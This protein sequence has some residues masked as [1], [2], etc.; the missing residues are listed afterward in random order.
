MKLCL[1]PIAL[2]VSILSAVPA[3]ADD[4]ADLK[5]Q[6][7][8]LSERV[9]NLEKELTRTT[10]TDT[11]AT[12]PTPVTISYP[13]S[14]Q[15]ISGDTT[16]SLYG[17]LDATFATQNHA[18]AF[19]NRGS[20]PVVSWM[21]GNRFGIN[22]SHTLDK[23]SGLK[24]IGRLE[25]E[26][27][28][29]T[30]N[31]D[32]PNVLF[33][34][35]AW[36]GLQ[37]EGLGKFTIGRQ[38]TLPR[39]FAQT[40]G[41]A[42]GSREVGLDEGG[43][44]NNNQMQYMINYAGGANGT[45]YNSAMVWKKQ[46]GQWVTGLAHQ[47]N[48]GGGYVPGAF[49]TGTTTAAAVA[50]NGGVWNVSGTFSRADIAGFIHQVVGIGGNVQ[51]SP[52][53]LVRAGYFHNSADQAVVGRRKDDVFTTSVT[54]TPSSLPRNQF[55]L[56]YYNIKANNAGYAA[57]G[58]TLGVNSDTSAVTTAADGHM[59]TFYAAAF[60][61]WDKQT[62]VYIAMD[63]VNTKD[64]FKYGFTNGFSSADELGVGLRFKF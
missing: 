31:M 38:N 21:S 19:G 23:A 34:R 2:A 1:T 35:D 62:D 26:F 40:W 17:I 51:I 14:M 36:V 33:N 64:G 52:E 50:Y 9:S 59:N 7:K 41:E 61:R 32:T 30:G 46:T 53:I 4:V 13:P 11:K 42:F 20:A 16:V 18:D 29:P 25:N 49:N 45:R 24:T 60:Y 15:L 6:N 28:L 27:E 5:A 56:G 39:D 22:A 43:W 54:F 8:S 48:G 44:N 63:V 57:N 10:T 37:S 12:E 47:F 58:N 3:Y 55:D